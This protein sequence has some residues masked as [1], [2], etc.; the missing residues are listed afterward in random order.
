[1]TIVV[2]TYAPDGLILASDSRTIFTRG[3]RHRV[4]T[5]HARKLFIPCKGIGIACFGTALLGDQTVAGLIGKFLAERRIKDFSTPAS[6]SVALEDFF[7]QQL[8]EYYRAVDEG[9]PKSA[10]PDL[11]EGLYG[12][13]VA[14]YVGGV[15]RV[16]E[17]LL[18]R[19]QDAI[20]EHD[21]STLDEALIFRGRTRYM[22]R[23]LE[24][25]DKYSLEL[26]QVT[27]SEEA[28]SDLRAVRL[29]VKRTISVQ[30]ALD[31]ATFVVHTTI[32]MERLTD[33][34]HARPGDVPRCGGQMQALLITQD[35]TSF[36]AASPLR[37]RRLGLA[38]S[39]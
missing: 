36:V 28:I 12:F 35:E 17:V 3:G 14:G 21:F 20:V 33:G 24:G 26:A 1:M 13:L 2:A 7:R 29:I 15:G 11:P 31:L 16:A 32:D 22:R 25:Y 10:P 18:P 4:A 6:V 19:K 8:D 23:M 30:N 37:V 9:D 27:L 34:I 39:D 5:D 38:D